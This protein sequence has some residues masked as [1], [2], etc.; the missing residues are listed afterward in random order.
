MSIRK[1]KRPD[2]TR[3]L[4][5]TRKL[6]LDVA[7]FEIF[8]KGFQGVS[9]DDI[10]KKTN[11][12][13]GAFYHH[14]PTKLDLGYALVDQ[15]I[16]PMIIDRW[17]TPLSN[18][19]NPLDGILIQMKNLIGKSDPLHLKL[20]CPLNNLVQEM[21]SVD[22]GFHKRLQVALNLWVDEMNKHLTRAKKS[23]YL[24][25]DVNTKHVALFV[26]MA[27]EGFYGMIKG[28]DDPKIF[29]A[30]Y[31]SLEIYFKTISI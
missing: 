17:I 4:I 24:K 9:V 19:D 2:R 29:K 7:F 13:K 21:S 25:A 23:G 20:G 14:F 3:N 11:L 22:P 6:I 31:G 27:H 12:T 10:V 1:T 16:K 28:L 30:L 26:V 8:Q 5:A 18:Y 15:V